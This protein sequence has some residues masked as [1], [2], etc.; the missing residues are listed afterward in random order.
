MSTQT[1]TRCT[2]QLVHLNIATSS[3]YHL[4]STLSIFLS[5]IG[6]ICTALAAEFELHSVVP[7]HVQ[8]QFNVNLDG[9]INIG[10][11]KRLNEFLKSIGFNPT[12]WCED[13][14]CDGDAVLLSLNSEGG[15]FQEALAITREFKNYIGFSNGY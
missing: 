13:A 15:E 9:R 1:N 11:H 14:D 5:L 10:D 6:S 7:T 3:H 4:L 8:R 12:T 2:K